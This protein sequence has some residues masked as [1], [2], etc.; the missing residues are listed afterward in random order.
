MPEDNVNGLDLIIGYHPVP[1][2]YLRWNE[3]GVLEQKWVGHDGE[4]WLPV[5]SLRVDEQAAK[6]QG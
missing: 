5:E 3:D 6:A 2:S 1:T 4:A